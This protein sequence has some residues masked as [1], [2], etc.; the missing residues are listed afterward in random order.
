MQQM[1]SL[2]VDRFATIDYQRF[3]QESAPLSFLANERRAILHRRERL[4]ELV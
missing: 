1:Q 2:G 4:S 3:R